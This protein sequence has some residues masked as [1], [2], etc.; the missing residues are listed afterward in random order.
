MLHAA[1]ASQWKK[2]VQFVVDTALRYFVDLPD[3]NGKTPHALAMELGCRSIARLLA[4]ASPAMSAASAASKP[5][6][7][8]LL[9]KSLKLFSS[10][11][12]QQRQ[13][14]PE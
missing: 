14:N 4:A 7:P 13:P 11:L 10:R 3:S 9:A 5:A 12:A 2:V 8:L 6:G 1:V